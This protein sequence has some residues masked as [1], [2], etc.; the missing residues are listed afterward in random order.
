MGI[1]IFV[2]L[3]SVQVAQVIEVCYIPFQHIGMTVGKGCPV[4]IKP[5]GCHGFVYAQGNQYYIKI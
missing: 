4:L 1:I 3:D 5:C 2:I